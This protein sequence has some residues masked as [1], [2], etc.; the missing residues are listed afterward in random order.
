MAE[1]R[2]LPFQKR[3]IDY[4]QLLKDISSQSWSEVCKETDVDK[5]FQLFHDIL[6]THISNNTTFK[7]IPHSKVKLK[8]WITDGLLKCIQKRNRLHRMHKKFPSESIVK[9]NYLKYR[10][11][12]N[13]IIKETREKYFRKKIYKH[14]GDSKKI[15][16]ILNEA[17]NRKTKQKLP[18][19]EMLINNKMVNFS[20]DLNNITNALNS[21]YCSVGHDLAKKHLHNIGVTE[22]KVIF[23][24]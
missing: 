21:F 20:S 7:T 2:K 11:I 6:S 17:S 4:E 22:C 12:C 18:I 19:K 1:Q 24:N 9:A 8:P 10:N 13:R 5:A 3:C 23:K 16:E 14:S 15:W